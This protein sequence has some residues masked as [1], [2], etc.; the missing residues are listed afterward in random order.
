MI[1]EYQWTGLLTPQP[2]LRDLEFALSFSKRCVCMQPSPAIAGVGEK[3]GA[4]WKRDDEVPRSRERL[5]SPRQAHLSA[6]E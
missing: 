1:W 5:S 2:K 3:L 4:E 6:K